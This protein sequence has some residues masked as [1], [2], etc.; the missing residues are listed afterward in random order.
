MGAADPTAEPADPADTAGAADGTVPVRSDGGGP[1]PHRRRPSEGA[2]WAPGTA[3]GA[4]VATPKRPRLDAH[5]RPGFEPVGIGQVRSIV[6]LEG[7]TNVLLFTYGATFAVLTA[8]AAALARRRNAVTVKVNG[9]DRQQALDAS[10]GLVHAT[11]VGLALIS[12]GLV[13]VSAA[14]CWVAA[15]NQQELAGEPTRPSPA[16]AAIGW[17]LPIANLL[18]PFRTVNALAE[19]PDGTDAVPGSVPSWWLA[20]LAAAGFAG[21]GAWQMNATSGDAGRP[22]LNVPASALIFAALGAAS[23]LYCFSQARDV[24]R[25]IARRQHDHAYG[26]VDPA[27]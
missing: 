5:P 13:I 18:V 1:T 16:V 14:W 7:L 6:H 8:F 20:W 15:K 4:W 23:F 12:V 10:S 25:H 19:G 22:N 3:P 9:D 21:A 11:V 27:A 26:V 2:I 17:F 24:F